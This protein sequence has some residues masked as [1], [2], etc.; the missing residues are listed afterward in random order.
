MPVDERS[1][2][3]WSLYGSANAMG[4][5]DGDL[6]RINARID[7]AE[8]AYSGVRMSLSTA[9]LAS[10]FGRRVLIVGRRIG[11]DKSSSCLQPAGAR[12]VINY[13]HGSS[14]WLYAQSAI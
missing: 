5:S 8:L 10:P 2:G 9:F 6:R 7:S 11:F 1:G 13:E 14:P 4:V 12:A 3:F